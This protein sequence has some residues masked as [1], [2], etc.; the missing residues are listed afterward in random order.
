MIEGFLVEE[1]AGVAAFLVEEMIAFLKA[2]EVAAAVAID[3]ERLIS[4]YTVSNQVAD[5]MP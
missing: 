1:A 3:G 5:G 2:G 4:C